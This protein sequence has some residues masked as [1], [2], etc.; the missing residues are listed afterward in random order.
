MHGLDQSTTPVSWPWWQK[1]VLF[2]VFSA[3]TNLKTK[4]KLQRVEEENVIIWQKPVAV[5]SFISF[6]RLHEVTTIE[7]FLNMH[8]TL[9]IS[10]CP[11]KCYLSC[12]VFCLRLC[13]SSQSHCSRDRMWK[14]WLITERMASLLKILSMLRWTGFIFFMFKCIFCDWVTEKLCVVLWITLVS[15]FLLLLCKKWE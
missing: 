6:I 15:T 12:F 2:P 14:K 9:T 7:A 10:K 1:S 5:F 3:L 13:F 11:F 8:P 4:M